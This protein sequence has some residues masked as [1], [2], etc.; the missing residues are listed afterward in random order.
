M[1]FTIDGVRPS[2][3]IVSHVESAKVA[4]FSRCS[5]KRRKRLS[6]V[7]RLAGL[8]INASGYLFRFRGIFGRELGLYRNEVLSLRNSATD[9]AGSRRGNNKKIRDIVVEKKKPCREYQPVTRKGNLRNREPLK[10]CKCNEQRDF[11]SLRCLIAKRFVG[12]ENVST[13]FDE[14]SID[15]I[16]FRR[17]DE[18]TVFQ[19]ERCKRRI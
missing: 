3:L 17:K 8:D 4:S 7:F 14:K 10:C 2:F 16:L 1:S 6:L 18:T 15:R 11:T 19:D 9:I 5:A 13:A 12:I